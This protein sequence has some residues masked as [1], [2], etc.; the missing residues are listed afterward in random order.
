MK[1][2]TR[3]LLLLIILIINFLFA[4][5]ENPLA[6]KV[7]QQEEKIN[8]QQIEIQRLRSEIN[9]LTSIVSDLQSSQDIQAQAIEDSMTINNQRILRLENTSYKI[10]KEVKK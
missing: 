10:I 1:L 2:K 7:K 4:F 6:E 8:Q 3:Q 9:R 5:G